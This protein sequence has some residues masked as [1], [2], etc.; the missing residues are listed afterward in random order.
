MRRFL[1]DPSQAR[2]RRAWLLLLLFTV[3][4][5]GIGIGRAIRGRPMSRALP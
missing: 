5:L 1:T 2:Y 3:V 4:L